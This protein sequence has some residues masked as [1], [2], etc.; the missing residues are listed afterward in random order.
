MAPAEAHRGR[1]R[2][3]VLLDATAIDDQRG[4]RPVRKGKQRHQ[5]LRGRGDRDGAITD[6]LVLEH[7]HPAPARVRAADH[8]ELGL[9]SVRS[10]CSLVT[11]IPI[12]SGARGERVSQITLTATRLGCPV[13]CRYCG[14]RGCRPSSR[15]LA[16]G[17]AHGLHRALP[18][19]Y[20]KRFTIRA[21]GPPALR[22]ALRG[23]AV[24]ELFTASTD[25][26][27]PSCRRSGPIPGGHLATA[28]GNHHFSHV[29]SLR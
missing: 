9:Q 18:R 14:A 3:P 11:S 21:A 1:A 24:R 17:I 10:H 16:G 5:P 4:H 28:G 23:G 12:I 27:H 25:V 2:S 7:Q 15:A 26:L 19:P 13:T 20:G 29:Q 22:D 8:I 6:A